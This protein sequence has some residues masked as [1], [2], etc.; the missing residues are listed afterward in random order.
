MNKNSLLLNIFT[1]GRRFEPDEAGSAMPD[2]KIRYILMNF[3]FIFGSLILAAF[4]VQNILKKSFFDATACAVMIVVAI[5]GF[6][7]ARVVRRQVIPAVFSMISYEMLCLLLIWNGDAQGAGFLFIYIYPLLTI[8]L[9]GMKTGILLSCSQLVIT[10]LQIFIPGASKFTYSF[11]VSI[12]M[13]TVYVL[14]LSITIVFERTRQTK[15]LLNQRLTTELKTLNENLQQ[16][17]EEKSGTLIKLH[18]TFGRYLPDKIIKQLLES[19]GGPSLWGEKRFI[20]I[21]TSDIRGF[22]SLAE[23]YESEKVVMMLNHYFSVMVEIIHTFSGTIIEYLGDSILCIFGA[24]LEDEDHADNAVACAL[25]MQAAMKEVNAWGR[26]NHFP[27]IE[28]GIAVNT[29]DAIVGNIGSDRVMKYNVIGSNVNLSSRI[30]SYT[31]GG[32]VMLSEYTYNAL[33]SPVRVVQKT[34]VTPKGVSK[35]LLIIQIDAIGEPFN[36]TLDSETVPLEQLDPPLTVLC[37]RIRDKQIEADGFEVLLTHLSRK[38][39]KLLLTGGTNTFAVFEELRLYIFDREVLAKIVDI[40]EKRMTVRFTS[41]GS[42]SQEFI[43]RGSNT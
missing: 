12:R 21:M 33:H 1:S 20:S 29:G 43:S 2:N 3:I 42:V 26:G 7:L 19:P 38:E 32:Q 24:P 36:I 16:M 31:T 22:T 17:V 34:H 39:G 35:P 14:V 40:E 15:D 25:K 18:D 28:M 13:V 37:F 9:M 6:S 27:E 4:V 8:L 23:E 11:D 41:Q 10:A 5:T 30:E